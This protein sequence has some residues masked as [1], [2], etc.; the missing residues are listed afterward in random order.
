LSVDVSNSLCA[1]AHRSMSGMRAFLRSELKAFDREKMKEKVQLS[2]TRLHLSVS[3]SLAVF[4]SY[5][6]PSLFFSGAFRLCGLFLRRPRAREIHLQLFLLTHLRTPEMTHY[7]AAKSLCNNS[8]EPRRRLK[9]EGANCD[10]S[11]RG[12]GGITLNRTAG[13]PKCAEKP[14]CFGPCLRS[15]TARFVRREQ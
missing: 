7:T 10:D 13:R 8:R 3:R 9:I 15:A 12:S 1:L 11:I 14:G 6:R 2:G 4:G 5:A